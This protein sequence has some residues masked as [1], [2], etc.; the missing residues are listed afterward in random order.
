MKKMNGTS[1]FSLNLTDEEKKHLLGIAYNTLRTYVKD[2]RFYEIPIDVLPNALKERYGVFVTLTRNKKLRGCT[3]K[4]ATNLPLYWAVQKMVISS[5]NDLRFPRIE[6]KEL[7]NIN[8]KISILSPLKRIK[9]VDNIILGRH[10]IYVYNNGKS[11]TF[12]PE[13]AIDNRFSPKEFVQ[14]CALYKAN[15]TMEEYENLN[16]YVY[17]TEI[18]E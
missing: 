6:E 17:Q 1:K 4:F 9:S 16:L 18:I 2:N 8:I 5:T 12:L 11:G 15:M 7:S 13:V 10:G 3:G 14:H